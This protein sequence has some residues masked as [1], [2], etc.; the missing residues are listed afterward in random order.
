MASPG[1]VLTHVFRRLSRSPMFTAI[2]LLTLAIRIGANTAVF[3]VFH[4]ILLKPL[5]FPNPDTFVGLWHSAPG[6]SL[7]QLNM[8]PA[9]MYTYS[10]EGKSFEH[11]GVWTTGTVGVTGTS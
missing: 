2:T 1:N 4:G 3:S 9:L 11:L 7:P 8:S 6:I 5:P 10:E